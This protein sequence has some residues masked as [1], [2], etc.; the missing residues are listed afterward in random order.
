MNRISFIL[1]LSMV[2]ACQTDSDTAGKKT[3]KENDRLSTNQNS[4]LSNEIDTALIGDQ[5]SRESNREAITKKDGSS[6]KNDPKT[7]RDYFML[8]PSK[9]FIIECCDGDKEAYL[10]QYL[11][12]EDTKNGYMDGG[13]DA[14][15]S[16]FRLALFKRPDKTY[17]VALNV[18]GELTDDYYFLDYNDGNWKDISREMIPEFSN[19]KIYEIPRRGTTIPVFEKRVIDTLESGNLTEKGKK[20]YDLSWQNGRF[21]IKK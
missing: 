18:F 11:G 17:V 2:V 12:V 7:V 16:T 8:L 9:Y 5:S 10:K 15:Q 1:I 13:G 6:D 21:K 20:L 3:T 14:A 19:N 4:S